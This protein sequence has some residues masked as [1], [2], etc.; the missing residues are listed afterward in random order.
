MLPSISRRARLRKSFAHR[1]SR[2]LRLLHQLLLSTS[3]DQKNFSYVRAEKWNH[4]QERMMSRWAHK[5]AFILERGQ[6]NSVS[7]LPLTNRGNVFTGIQ[8]KLRPRQQDRDGT[9]A[10][11][12][13]L[14]PVKDARLSVS[15]VA[16]VSLLRPDAFCGFCRT[17]EGPICGRPHRCS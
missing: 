12:Q 2:L 9:S 5:N 15:Q 8:N 11:R 7:S 10:Q 3:S 13:A 4:T 1:A 16:S 17:L 6:Q 14:K